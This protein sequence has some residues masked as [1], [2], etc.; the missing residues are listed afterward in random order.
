[1]TLNEV[2][3]LSLLFFIS[4]SKDKEQYGRYLLLIVVVSEKTFLKSVSALMYNRKEP[5][6]WHSAFAFGEK[7]YDWAKVSKKYQL[8]GVASKP[9][10]MF[11][12][13]SK[14]G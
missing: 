4:L 7:K 6:H 10:I 5:I 13:S 1:M 11:H 14:V 9:L 8:Q 3:T 12:S 2:A